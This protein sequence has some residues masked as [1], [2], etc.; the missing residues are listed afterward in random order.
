M[1]WMDDTTTRKTV[2]LLEQLRHVLPARGRVLILPHDHPD[3]DALA[4]AAALHL[5]LHQR[6]GLNGQIVFTGLVARAENQEMLRHFRYRWRHPNELRTPAKK[7][8]TIFVDTAPWTGNV[9][10]PSYAE[11][12]AVIDHHPVR[13]R[14]VPMVPFADIRQGAGA[15]ATILH[16]YLEAVGVA[17]PKWLATLLIYAII[18]ET[19]DLSRDSGP[20]DL[21][22]YVDLL[23]RANLKTLGRIRHAPLTREYFS[24]MKEAMDNGQV[25]GRVA[26]THLHQVKQTEIVAE[27]ADFLLRMERISWAFCTA[28]REDRLVV[29]L[30]S[31]ASRA[32]CGQLLRTLIG[33]SGAAGGHNHMAA[34][35]VAMKSMKPAT[36]E[37]KRGELV[38]G[39]LRRI[40]RRTPRQAGDAAAPLAPQPLVMASAVQE[41]REAREATPN[42]GQPS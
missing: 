1:G 37:T 33:R 18:T 25:F 29:S 13:R 14:A 27:L 5:L 23:T 26:F 21:E 24:H 2:K 3:P 12:V 19:L 15:T 36:R 28:Y 17:P 9:T 39:L 30:R 31:S 6:F 20:E 10:I 7:I 11:P 40:E 41:S 42:A 4:S 22:A 35:F 16:Q 38:Q 34:G 8:P 32:R